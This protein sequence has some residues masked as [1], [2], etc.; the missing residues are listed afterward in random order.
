[1]DKTLPSFMFYEFEYNGYYLR[2]VPDRYYNNKDGEGLATV[3]SFM[4]VG[5]NDSKKTISYMYFYDFD[6]DVISDKGREDG[7]SEKFKQKEMRSFLKTYFY[8]Y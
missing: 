8:W 6:L 3:K 1:M 2:I 5:F 7:A 4:F